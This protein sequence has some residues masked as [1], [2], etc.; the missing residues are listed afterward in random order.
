MKEKMHQF[1]LSLLNDDYGINSEAWNQLLEILDELE[2]TDIPLQV[3]ATDGRWYL[4]E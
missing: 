2:I 4:P 1:A 3:R